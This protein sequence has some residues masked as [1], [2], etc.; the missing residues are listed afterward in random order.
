MKP[1]LR[2]LG[3]QRVV[4]IYAKSAQ[5]GRYGS[6]Y[7]VGDDL[8]LTA[9]HVVPDAASYL[10]RTLDYDQFDAEVV[11]S[12]SPGRL[13]AA[14]LRVDGAPWR[15]DADRDALRWGKVAENGVKCWALGFP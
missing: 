2:R 10:V 4:D 5:T 8:V 11:W 15:N 3:A 9:A 6:G 7:A 13:D 12:G 1:E 14:L